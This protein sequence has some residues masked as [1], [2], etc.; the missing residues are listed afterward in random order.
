MGK[1]TR[2]QQRPPSKRK[3]SDLQVDRKQ[4][5]QVGPRARVVVKEVVDRHV[6]PAERP[7]P[8]QGT[9]AATQGTAMELGETQGLQGTTYFSPQPKPANPSLTYK[10]PQTMEQVLYY[11]TR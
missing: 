3:P 4:K 10:S 8:R 5:V 2:H 6:G 9:L 11:W 1:T 7:Q